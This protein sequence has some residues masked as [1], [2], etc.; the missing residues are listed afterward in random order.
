MRNLS[1]LRHRE[2]LAWT[3]ALCLFALWSDPAWAQVGGEIPGGTYLISMMDTIV[4]FI[5]MNLGPIVVVLVVFAGVFGCAAG[6]WNRGMGR[7][8]MGLVAGAF[9]AGSTLWWPWVKTW[10]TA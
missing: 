5:R 6:D 7:V 2:A 3:F 10:F 1:K 8:V 4:S 9:I